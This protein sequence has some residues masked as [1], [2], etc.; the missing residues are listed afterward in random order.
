M[1]LFSSPFGTV[2]HGRF[3]IDFGEK[4]HIPEPFDG[5][6]DTAEFP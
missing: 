6:I 1:T 2:Y 3:T 4:I 5:T